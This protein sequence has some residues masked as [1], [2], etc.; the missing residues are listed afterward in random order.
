L[1]EAAILLRNTFFASSPT[2]P[3]LEYSNQ[4]GLSIWIDEILYKNVLIF[5]KHD[6]NI[7]TGNIP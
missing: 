5:Q 6:I 1:F 7:D 3:P 2:P 4:G